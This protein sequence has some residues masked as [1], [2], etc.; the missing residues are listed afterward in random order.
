MRVLLASEDEQS[1]EGEKLSHLVRDRYVPP[2]V[3]HAPTEKNH[4]GW[5]RAITR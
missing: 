1:N 3:V 4:E 5:D 2:T